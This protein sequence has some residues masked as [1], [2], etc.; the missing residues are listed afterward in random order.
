MYKRAI[1]TA[2][3]LSESPSVSSMAPSLDVFLH[4]LAMLPS[5]QS[6][7][8]LAIIMSMNGKKAHLLTMPYTSGMIRK[9]FAMVT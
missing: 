9:K 7:A 5:K 4:S 8:V 3:R 2:V 1:E 6:S